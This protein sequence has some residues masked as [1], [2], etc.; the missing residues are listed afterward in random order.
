MDACYLGVDLGGTNVVMGLLEGGGRIL[1]R[2]SQPT[3]AALGPESLVERI[4]ACGAELIGRSKLRADQVKAVGIGSPGP[5]S[6]AKGKIITSCNLPGFK[7]F[8]LR[9]AC[10]EALGLPALLD[11]DANAAC[12]GEFWR[13]AGRDV[14]DMVLFTLGTGIGGGIVCAGELVHGSGDNAAELGHMIIVPEGRGCT[15]G[16]RGC[17]EAYA[18]ANSTVKRALEALA[19]DRQSSLR[20]TIKDRGAITSKDIFDQARS[21]DELALEIVDGTAKALAIACINMNHVTEPQKVV[22]AGGMIQ[23][24][25]ILISKVRQFY[26]EMIWQADLEPMEICLAELG[27]DAG[28]IGAAGLALHAYRHNRLAPVGS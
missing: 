14:D 6:I 1:A 23:A 24:G 22:L 4:A 10:S 28:I 9:A 8:A 26:R 18:S 20:Q 11:N 19:K 15:C 5:L 27:G 25:E 2:K 3:Q 7:D 13:G 16:Q 12:W 21:G 17:L